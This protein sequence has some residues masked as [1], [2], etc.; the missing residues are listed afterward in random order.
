[1]GKGVSPERAHKY[2]CQFIEGSCVQVS[3][4]RLFTGTGVSP[5]RVRE[6]RCQSREGS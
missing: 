6:Y 1:M 3:V 2:K 5:E 4:H